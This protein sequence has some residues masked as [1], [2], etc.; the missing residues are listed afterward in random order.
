[1]SQFIKIII[2]K[3]KKDFK[4][5]QYLPQIISLYERFSRYLHDDYFLENKNRSIDAVLALVEK[6]S[7]YFWAVIDKKSG[8]LSGFVFLDNWVGAK[9][10]FH[11]AEVTT[12]FN[13]TFWG[14]YTK[15]CAKKFIKYSFK[16]FKLKK[17][18]A[19]IFPQ[20]Y[21]VKTLLKCA[22]FKKEAVLKAETM[23]NGIFQDIEVFSVFSEE[24]IHKNYER[25]G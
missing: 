11:S 6:T 17:I 1:M 16:K 13:P 3:Q 20:N 7:P 21:K 14:K 15:I 24:V 9:N 19:Y 10:D 2:N 8:K 22:G 23:K 12:C 5:I 25:R 18:K 4:N